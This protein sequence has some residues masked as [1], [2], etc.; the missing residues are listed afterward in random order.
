[1]IIVSWP[2]PNELG[3]GDWFGTGIAVRP[4][5]ALTMRNHSTTQSWWGVVSSDRIMARLLCR[6]STMSGSD[7]QASAVPAGM[8]PVEGARGGRSRPFQRIGERGI[9]LQAKFG[10]TFR[11]FF[12]RGEEW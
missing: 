2:D 5:A 10:F 4:S 6:R 12:T 1:V 3:D 9:S 8:S 7:A 11:V